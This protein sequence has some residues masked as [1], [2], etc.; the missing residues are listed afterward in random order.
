VS[1]YSKD[2]AFY[3]KTDISDEAAVTESC[4]AAL[5]V[6]PKGSLFGGVHCAAISRSRQWSNKMTDSCKVRLGKVFC[7]EGKDD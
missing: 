3:F 7:T 4:N 2:R 6:I 5:R 1:T